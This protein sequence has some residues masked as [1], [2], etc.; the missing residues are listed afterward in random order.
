MLHL[1]INLVS[2]QQPIPS[3]PFALELLSTLSLGLLG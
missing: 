1:P 3:F 2:H